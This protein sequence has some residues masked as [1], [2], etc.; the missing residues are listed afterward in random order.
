MSLGSLRVDALRWNAEGDTVFA[1]LYDYAGGDGV[2][3]TIAYPSGA[4]RE[5]HRGPGILSLASIAVTPPGPVWLENASDAFELWTEHASGV[6]RLA[7]L[8]GNVV[9][10]RAT[11]EEILALEPTSN[12]RIVR[13]A[14]GGGSVVFEPVVASTELIESFDLDSAGNLVYSVSDGPGTAT[15]FEMRTASGTVR[16]QPSGRLVG[17]PFFGPDPGLIYYE[18]HDQ[19]AVLAVDPTTGERSTILAV[20]ASEP[21]FS[22]GGIL[23][24]TGVSPERVQEVCFATPAGAYSTPTVT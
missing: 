10:L 5:I 2:V 18:D 24:H 7:I 8:P 16:I 11:G 9:N 15:F 21:A 17:G 22:A 3:G 14:L 20:D 12:G 6:H 4:F 13:V 23:A 1:A 19:G